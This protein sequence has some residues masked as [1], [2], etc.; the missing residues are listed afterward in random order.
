MKK[1]FSILVFFTIVTNAFA[2]FD[3]VASK[4]TITD[5][6]VD[7]DNFFVVVEAAT[8]S[9]EYELAFDLWPAVHSAIGS[10]DANDGTIG[11]V[12]SYVHK[13]MANGSSVNMWYYP[14]DFSPISLSIVSN[15]DKTCTLSGSIQAERNGVAYTYNIAPFVFDYDE[16]E[17]VVPQ[18][19]PYRFEP[20]DAT[21]FDFVA[22]VINYRQRDGYIEI[23]LNE[24]AN[25]T[26][27]WID[28]RWLSD[29]MPM[30]A[31]V[32][33]INDSGL[34]GTLTASAGYL[35]STK[36]DDPC[37]VAIRGDK[38]F[39]GQYTPYY[40][41]SGSLTVEYNTKGDTVTI[42]GDVHSYNGSTIHVLAK[43]YNMFYDPDV[44]P[45]EPEDVTLAVDS[46]AIAYLS[47]ESD[48]LSNLYRYTMDFTAG[49][50]YPYVLVDVIMS[51]PMELVEGTYTLADGNLL[52]LRLFQNQSDFNEAFFGGTPYE[53]ETASLTLTKVSNTAWNFSMLITDAIGSKYHFSLTKEPKIILY[54]Q[55]DDPSLKDQPYSDEQKEATN[56][57]IKLDSI[58]WI[59]TTVAD[60]GILDIVLT[61]RNADSNGLRAYVHLGMFTDVEYPNAGVYAVSS[62]EEN[63]TFNASLGKYGN[64]KIPCYVV[65][66]NDDLEQAVWYLVSGNIQISYTDNG[67]PLIS[68][69][70]QTYFGSTIN[71]S[72]SQISSGIENIE[73]SGNSDYRKFFRDGQVLIQKQGKTYSVSGQIAK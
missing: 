1:F 25:E 65:Y 6:T 70:C 37:Y 20:T 32:Y 43:G 72:Y 38:E 19:E 49:D 71:F 33:N 34:A 50:D 44:Q 10:F 51:K 28:L 16:E 66:K 12:S 31:G 56:L 48:S 2:A 68:G 36:G 18:E 55:E 24:M 39:W 30:T 52:D 45:R 40:L 9:G 23:T 35:G 61:Q 60:D 64:T 7:K 63:G 3:V 59:T 15:G 42:S 73:T 67:Q 58:Q 5:L 53:F 8:S 22:D 26:Y 27:N 54:P 57:T 11:Y 17:V 4:V 21:E 29:D 46:V 69:E 47:N 41:T 13:V 62:S 14:E